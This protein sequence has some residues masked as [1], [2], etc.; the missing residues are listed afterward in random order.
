MIIAALTFLVCLSLLV[1]LAQVASTVRGR[2][3][4]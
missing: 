2:H 3:R 1:F 4:R